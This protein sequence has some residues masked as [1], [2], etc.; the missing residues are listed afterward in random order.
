MCNIHICDNHIKRIGVWV[1]DYSKA[2]RGNGMEPEFS[3]DRIRLETLRGAPPIMPWRVF[4]DWIGMGD[5]HG[6]VQAWCQRGYL[7][8]YRIGKHVMVNIALLTKQLLEGDE[9]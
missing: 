7:P 5:E 3:A 6:V 1:A 9:I 8:T 2:K 4:A